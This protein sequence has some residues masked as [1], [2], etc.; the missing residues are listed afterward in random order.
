METD[1]LLCSSRALITYLGDRAF[2]FAARD[3]MVIL[4]ECDYRNQRIQN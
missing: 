4:S 1:P 3:S 2:E